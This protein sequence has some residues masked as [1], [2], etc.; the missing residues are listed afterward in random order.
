[1]KAAPR[2]NGFALEAETEAERELLGKFAQF[3]IRISGTSCTKETP[4]WKCDRIYFAQNQ[5]ENHLNP[6]KTFP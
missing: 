5:Q 6:P 4:A 2:L 3:G 1:M